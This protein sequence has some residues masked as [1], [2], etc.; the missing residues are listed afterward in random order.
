MCILY[1]DKSNITFHMIESHMMHIERDAQ[2]TY[3]LANSFL[4]TAFSASLRF[5]LFSLSLKFLSL[6]FLSRRNRCILLYFISKY[7]FVRS[8]FSRVS[9]LNDL[10]ISSLTSFWIWIYNT[11]E[12][13]LI[14]IYLCTSMQYLS[15]YAILCICNI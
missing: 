15:M 10:R 11:R 4:A 9:L 13:L 3:P 6:L 5:D 7:S 2:K 8:A 12:T 1:M 14:G